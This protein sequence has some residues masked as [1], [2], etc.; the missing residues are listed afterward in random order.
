[1]LRILHIS[2]THNESR[3]MT[4]LNNLA[5]QHKECEVIALTG[6]VLSSTM[7]PLTATWNLWPHKLKL[8]VPGDH[9]D[10]SHAYD[11]LGK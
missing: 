4:R 6:D 9:Y 11:L 1:M 8:A 10:H 7:E 3:T 5:L 2:D